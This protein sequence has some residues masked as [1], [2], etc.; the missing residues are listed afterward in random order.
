MALLPRVPPGRC[1]SSLLMVHLAQVARQQGWSCPALPAGM[2]LFLTIQRGP[3]M[4]TA[5]QGQ[6]PGTSTPGHLLLQPGG[7]VVSREGWERA[8][9]KWGMQCPHQ[10]SPSSCF[11]P[12]PY[13]V[14]LPQPCSLLS[15]S[16][17]AVAGPASSFSSPGSRGCTKIKYINT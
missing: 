10:T 3:L 12:I 13:S 6:L 4:G 7:W 11:S 9:A 2:W 1:A 16:G 14:L 15:G 5:E 17:G 8:S